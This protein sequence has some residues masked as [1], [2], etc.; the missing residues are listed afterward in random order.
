MRSHTFMRVT[1]GLRKM[2]AQIKS[3]REF[4]RL[5]LPGASAVALWSARTIVN[6][7]MPTRGEWLDGRASILDALSEHKF[8]F[9][10][11]QNP[12]YIHTN[13]RRTPW[14]ETSFR[15]RRAPW[16]KTLLRASR[17]TETLW[18]AVD[19]EN[20]KCE[21]RQPIEVSGAIDNSQLFSRLDFT[22]FFL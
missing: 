16:Y 8:F 10:P 12:N 2:G 11:A 5:W 4:V 1:A 18:G 14:I 7:Y 15:R 22:C 20:T 19:S 3:T 13:T 9:P 6:A 17:P 21:F